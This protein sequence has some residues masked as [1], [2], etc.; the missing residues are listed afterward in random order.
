MEVA[1]LVAVHGDLA[2]TAAQHRAFSRRNLVER[3]NVAS[4]DPVSGE[5]R[6]HVQIL[7]RE[8]RDGAK[9]NALRIVDAR[10]RIRVAANQVAEENAGHRP[11][12]HSVAGISGGDVD[13]L[14]I[15]RIGSDELDRIDRLHDLSGPPPHG[16][17]H[18][19]EALA[20]PL[21]QLDEALFDAVRLSGL[22]IFSAHDEDFLLAGAGTV[23]DAP[24]THVMVGRGCIALVLRVLSGVPEE[25]MRDDPGCDQGGDHVAAIGGLFGMNRDALVDRRVRRDHD[26]IRRHHRPGLR[27]H[28]RR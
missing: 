9:R 2:E 12:R 11:A 24:H 20:G 1:A 3:G 21:F 18:G 8:L 15:R 16:A 7:F 17:S 28:A 6:R 13:V 27:F 22:M 10:P 23:S 5:M 26:R 25:R 14:L 19:S 4:L